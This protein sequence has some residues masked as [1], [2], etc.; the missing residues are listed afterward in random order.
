M[1]S[2]TSMSFFHLWPTNPRQAFFSAVVFLTSASWI[3]MV[4]L[5]FLSQYCLLH[6]FSVTHL[7]AGESPKSPSNPCLQ[8]FGVVVHGS[9][10]IK[11]PQGRNSELFHILI[12]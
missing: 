12:V 6:V 10:I 11:F 1:K 7:P 8:Q 3:A 4:L 2:R 5:S 9:L